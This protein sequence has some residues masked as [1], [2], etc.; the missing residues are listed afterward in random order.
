VLAAVRSL[1]RRSL[2][3]SH[4]ALASAGER[5]AHMRGARLLGRYTTMTEVSARGCDSS[6]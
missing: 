3:A 1:R 4:S 2:S 5:R 6:K